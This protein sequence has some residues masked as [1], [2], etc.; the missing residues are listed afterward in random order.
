MVSAASTFEGLGG[1]ASL[2]QDETAIPLSIN[3]GTSFPMP[4][5]PFTTA[6]QHPSAGYLPYPGT[7]FMMMPSATAH[8][9]SSSGIGG[10]ATAVLPTAMSS[11]H[12]QGAGGMVT[13]G[14]SASLNEQAAAVA[15]NFTNGPFHFSSEPSAGVG[16]SANSSS[17]NLYPGS[18]FYFPYGWSA[19]LA[20]AQNSGNPINVM[21][22]A[23]GSAV[24]GA[25][26]KEDGEVP[27]TAGQ[28]CGDLVDTVNQK[29]QEETAKST[30][31]KS[32]STRQRSAQQ[33][34][35]GTV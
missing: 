25:S 2:R 23:D 15:A 21:S 7:P 28:S 27:A 14:S 3:N 12:V 22:A 5:F 26:M 4:A 30:V 13:A 29:D 19:G 8:G 35:A 20:S 11:E 1:G 9:G 32:K 17:S 31:K 33:S 10:M 18:F 16:G 34:S 24:P 6:S